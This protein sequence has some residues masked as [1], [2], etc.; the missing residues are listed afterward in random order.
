MDR[1]PNHVCKYSKC[2]QKYYACNRSLDG[3]T[4]WKSMCCCPEHYQK[5]M[6]EVFDA[7]NP[8]F[9]S[10]KNKKQR[11]PAHDRVNTDAVP[12]NNE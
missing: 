5:Y 7:R 12:A 3:S 2:H 10:E 4:H 11:G 6:Q 9:V 8:V 1:K